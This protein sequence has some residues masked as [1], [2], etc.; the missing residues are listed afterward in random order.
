MNSRFNLIDNISFI[1]LVMFGLLVLSLIAM[2]VL[3]RKQ[4][5]AERRAQNLAKALRKEVQ[6]M[7]STT[8]GM[9]KKMVDIETKL[10]TSMEKQLELAERDPDDVAYKQAARLVEMGA[11]VDDLV[12]SCGIGRPEAELMT[13][14]HREL[15][16]RQG[17]KKH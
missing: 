2:A 6:A 7:T 1:N 3:F 10:N 9:G 14:M 8:I 5:N 15:S 11:D 16:P 13:L 12:H 4:Q 17:L